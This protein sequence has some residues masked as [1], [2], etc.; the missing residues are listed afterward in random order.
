M[1]LS[2][3]SSDVLKL[4]PRQDKL[5]KNYKS[6]G[7][8][9][10]SPKLRVPGANTIVA[11]KASAA[12]RKK[13]EPVGTKGKSAKGPKTLSSLPTN[14]MTQSD[15]G[16]GKISPHAMLSRE[17][18]LSL[19]DKLRALED[20]THLADKRKLEMRKKTKEKT[21]EE[22]EAEWAL[23]D[24]V[25][26]ADFDAATLKEI[27]RTFCRDPGSR[28]KGSL[29]PLIQWSKTIDIFYGV[30]KAERTML[31]K[32]GMGR[33]MKYN[34]V[35]IG[36]GATDCPICVVFEGQ[37][38]IYVPGSTGLMSYIGEEQKQKRK[39]KHIAQTTRRE[40]IQINKSG[41]ISPT[42]TGR[43]ASVVAGSERRGSI[44]AENMGVSSGRRASVVAGADGG[45]R[46]SIVANTAGGGR[47]GSIVRGQM[48]PRAGEG[49]TSPR[50]GDVSTMVH[51][52][53]GRRASIVARNTGRRASIVA[54][55]SGRRSSVAA[56]DSGRRSSIV[57][58]RASVVSGTGDARRGS[59]V[60]GIDSEGN[61]IITNT[62]REKRVQEMQQDE[63]I[64][65]ENAGKCPM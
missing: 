1:A 20:S 39:L 8:T 37:A 62:G 48:S 2:A 28:T 42:A 40:S 9:A 14:Y 45:R 49:D 38:E 19:A 52:Q 29:V 6:T 21:Q 59:I 30:S 53:S 56:N 65:V 23:E 64:V 7:K 54:N 61:T 4:T 12:G 34:E 35:V 3:A 57:A 43:R 22:L 50:P 60:A 31:M 63:E 46:A 16:D 5:V 51:G 33:R 10:S 55:D 27:G 26:C 17:K 58:R 41:D 47:R 25:E 15:P 13:L 32:E 11:S 18:H 44:T 36:V 24:P